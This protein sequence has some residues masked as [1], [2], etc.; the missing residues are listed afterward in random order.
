MKRGDESTG[1][2]T[3]RINSS[4]SSSV[5]QCN[6]YTTKPKSTNSQPNRELPFSN[7]HPHP[8]PFP[9]QNLENRGNITNTHSDPAFI[10]P[11]RSVGFNDDTYRQYTDTSMIPYVKE[12][13]KL[14][15]I[16]E[17]ILSLMS[18]ESDLLTSNAQRLPFD[19]LN[20]SLLDWRKNLPD[21]ADFKMWD[22]IDQ[23][24][25]PSIAAIQS[26]LP[27]LRV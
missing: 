25:K 22:T 2:V 24:L 9:P 1:A 6:S 12:Q 18:S 11:W 5:A 16:V 8:L 14:A 19:S 23:P 3:S 17:R 26:V 13:I 21:W 27:Y 10:L 15:R 4:V 20:Q 7:F